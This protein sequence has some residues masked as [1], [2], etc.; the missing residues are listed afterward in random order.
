M[1]IPNYYKEGVFDCSERSAYVEWYLENHGIPARIVVGYAKPFL[2]EGGNHAWVEAYVKA[3]IYGYGWVRIET[4]EMSLF[5]GVYIHTLT[6]FDAL[7]TEYEPKI[8][9]EDIYEAVRYYRSTIEW[10]WWNV[11]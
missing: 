3:G 4:S 5:G 8:Y 6:I 1:P 9:F 7:F 10:D 11:E 2:G